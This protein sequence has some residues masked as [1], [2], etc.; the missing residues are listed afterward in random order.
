MK[1]LVIISIYD[2]GCWF[3]VMIDDEIYNA[4][5]R[6]ELFDKIVQVY[7]EFLT[8]DFKKWIKNKF[9]NKTVIICEDG[10]I[11]VIK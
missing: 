10:D 7:T 11:E 6:N 4:N 1:D 2:Y 8:N 3:S 9:K 5:N